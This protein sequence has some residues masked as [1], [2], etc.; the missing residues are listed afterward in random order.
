MYPSGYGG[1]LEIHWGLPAQVRTLPS[2][3]FLHTYRPYGVAVALRIPNPSTAVRFRL[4]SLL[5]FTYLQMHGYVKQGKPK[6]IQ[7]DGYIA[8]W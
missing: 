2:A 5:F 1:G 8:Q 7:V 3:F 4:G 6:S